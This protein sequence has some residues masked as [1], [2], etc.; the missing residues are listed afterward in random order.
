MDSDLDPYGMV[1]LFTLGRMD[2]ANIISISKKFDSW[3]GDAFNNIMDYCVF[4]VT[5][6]ISTTIQAYE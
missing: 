6:R 5:F 1:D 2:N 3:L 4:D